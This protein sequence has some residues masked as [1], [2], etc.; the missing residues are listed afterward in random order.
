MSIQRE[1]AVKRSPSPSSARES[2]FRRQGCVAFAAALTATLLLSALATAQPTRSS[3]D[4]PSASPGVLVDLSANEYFDNAGTNPRITSAV[5]SN[6][7]YLDDSSTRIAEGKAWFQVKAAAQLNA[8]ASPPSEEFTFTVQLTMTNDEDQ[9]ATG[10]VTVNSSYTRNPTP[11]TPTPPAKTPTFSGSQAARNARPG[12]VVS[13]SAEDEF[14]DAGTN[15]IF[16][17]AVFSTMA[18]YDDTSTGIDPSKGILLV[19]AKTAAELNA[20]ASP[21]DSPFTVTVEVTMTNDEGQTATGTMTFETTYVR[22]P[23]PATPT[24]TFTGSQAARNAPPGIAISVSAADEF[25]DAGTNPRFIGTVYSTTAYY[26]DKSTGIDSSTGNL[27]VQ[28]KTTAELNALASPPDSPFTVTVEVTMTN[29]EGATA[30]GT[31]TFTTSYT[32]TPSGGGP[33]VSEPESS[34][35]GDG[36]G[37]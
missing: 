18:Y 37:D 32:R 19:G 22:D 9:T 17:G 14:D 26:D 28:A 6:P 27:V 35:D 31:L 11:L 30:S 33:D 21:P 24:P 16:T 8:L 12:I 5:Y 36:A 1:R 15:P 10:T 25:D 13:T 29:D 7:E 20:L 2:G 4:G 3:N 23:T 34:P